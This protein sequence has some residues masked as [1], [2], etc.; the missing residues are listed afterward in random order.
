[1]RELLK[2]ERIDQDLSKNE[3][4]LEY[5]AM[6]DSDKLLQWNVVGLQ[7]AL[8]S[9]LVLPTYV[10]TMTLGSGFSHG[11]LTRAI[12]CRVKQD[13]LDGFLKRDGFRHGRMARGG[14][15]LTEVSSGPVMPNPSTPCG[16]AAGC[17]VCGR[18]LPLRTPYAIRLW[19]QGQ[20]SHGRESDSVS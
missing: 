15:R 8:L 3:Y 20:P 12:C 7:G 17:G 2:L 4:I 16:W 14:Q 5:S 19:I 13:L 11:H 18:L 1:M 6:S 9:Q 10:Q